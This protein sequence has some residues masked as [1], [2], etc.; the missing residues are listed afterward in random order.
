MIEKIGAIFT[1]WDTIPDSLGLKN[2]ESWGAIGDY[3]AGVYGTMASILL[4]ILTLSVVAFE[5]FRNRTNDKRERS[6]NH[7]Y[8]LLDQFSEIS[9][10]LRLRNDDSKDVFS[11]FI[12]EFRIAY[13]LSNT[14]PSG[15]R[16]NTAYIITLFGP[17]LTAKQ[18]I[19]EQDIDKAIVANLIKQI[20]ALRNGNTNLFCGFIGILGNYQRSLY[21]AYRYIQTSP[22]PKDEKQSFAKLLRTQMTTNEQAVLAVNSLSKLGHKWIEDGLINDFQVIKNVPKNYFDWGEDG[23]D[24]A[25]LFPKV[26]F[27]YQDYLVTS[28]YST[29]F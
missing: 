1:P 23:I 14:V 25:K 6:A 11:Q 24:I 26:V 28:D 19:E 12:S 15:L 16:I 29:G 2:P 5:Y 3:V 18:I 20:S 13:R 7:F 17:T 4:S 8:R 9:S 27:E 21:F 22:F 10:P